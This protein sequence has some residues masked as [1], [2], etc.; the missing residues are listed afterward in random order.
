MF[1]KEFGMLG[2]S[3][4]QASF[5]NMCGYGRTRIEAISNVLGRINV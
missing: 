5:G 4:Y 2:G 1:V 3:Y